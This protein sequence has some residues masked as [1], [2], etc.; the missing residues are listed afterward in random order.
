MNFLNKY[1]T[2]AKCSQSEPVNLFLSLMGI[3]S[4]LCFRMPIGQGLIILLTFYFKAEANSSFPYDNNYGSYYQFASTLKSL[5]SPKIISGEQEPIGD[6]QNRSE[7]FSWLN[8]LLSNQN[9]DRQIISFWKN[10]I[11]SP[12]LLSVDGHVKY[13]KALLGSQLL[14]DKP[15]PTTSH[16]K[17]SDLRIACVTPQTPILS[18]GDVNVICPETTTNLVSLI[19]SVTPDSETLEFHTSTTP[20]STSLVLDP[21]LAVMGKYYAF[22]R[23][24]S[25][26][27]YSIASTAI[28]VHYVSPTPVIVSTDPQCDVINGGVYVLNPVAGAIYTIWPNQSV[29]RPPHYSVVAPPNSGPYTV[30]SSMPGC[31]I[32]NSSNAVSVA[33][34]PI[35]CS[36]PVE[37]IFFDVKS[38]L[39]IASLFWTTSEE[40]NSRYFE[41]QHGTN[42]KLWTSIGKVTSSGESKIKSDYKFVHES[43]VAGTNYYRL[44]M[45]DNDETFSYSKIQKAHFENIQQLSVYPN[46]VSDALLVKDPYNTFKSADIIN[47]KGDIVYSGKSF[48]INGIDV[49][50]FGAGLYVVRI[51]HTNNKST[52]HKIV[53][54]K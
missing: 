3:I 20:S 23:N 48:P 37:L 6:Q 34:I 15:L 10:D 27:C 52:L 30:T 28:N 47:R 39:G 51:L 36:I 19:T 1:F 41:I 9:G 11:F 13:E 35:D 54:D 46:P 25:G 17:K 4:K 29:V 26:E 18:S 33:D 43:P 42:E 45:V 12:F 24:A 5:V 7:H 21:T 14:D 53:I 31:N 44:K 49:K 2:H 40:T 38:E 50:L 8:S 32:S 22:Y 16:N